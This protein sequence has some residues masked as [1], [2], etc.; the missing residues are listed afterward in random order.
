M[1]MSPGAPL[2]R[3]WLVT[4]GLLV[5]LL[6]VFAVFEQRGVPLLRDPSRLLAAGGSWAAAVSLALLIGDVFLPVPSSVLMIGNGALFGVVAGTALSLAG[7][8]GAAA[9][10]FFIGRRS[11]RL[12]E[13]LVSPGEKA[14]ADA[15]L[16]RWG[17]LAIVV[18]RPIPLL[19]ETTAI[20]AGGSPLGWPRLLAASAAGAFPSSLLYALTGAHSRS[21]GSGALVFG[22]VLVVAG[23]FY[24]LGTRDRPS[25]R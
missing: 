9:L 19:A 23:G 18:T 10:A 14:H 8:V 13:R 24:F 25:G 3:Y 17:A 21:F 15:L 20:L 7:S 16:A 4:L 1:T 12:I 11:E 5:L 6:V 2:R 22:I